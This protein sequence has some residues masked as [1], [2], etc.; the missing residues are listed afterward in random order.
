MTQVESLEA[1]LI[2]G[3]ALVR[4]RGEDLLDRARDGLRKLGVRD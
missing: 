3:L 1:A 2:L 4:T